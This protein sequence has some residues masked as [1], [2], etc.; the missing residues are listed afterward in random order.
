VVTA[1][2]AVGN[3]RETPMKLTDTQLV[4][5]SAAS[6]R[7]D[8]AIDRG[9]DLKGAASHKVIARLLKEGLVEETPARG[10]VPIWRR[11]D[12]TGPIALRM[13]DRGLAAIGVQ[14]AI[15]SQSA[16]EAS[17]AHDGEGPRAKTNRGRTEQRR[18]SGARHEPSRSPDGRSSKQARVIA[19]LQ[20]QQGA[21]I[22]AIMK[23]TGWQQH[24]VRGFFAGVV[25]KNLGLTLVSEKTGDQ[26]VY[27]I[28][29]GRTTAKGKRKA[30]R[31][32]R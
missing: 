23:A 1:R 10:S 31:K 18:R 13:T 3:R 30:A 26:R 17:Q 19:L 25:R 27:R 9:P 11:D 20:R 32:A 28:T 16:G 24:S 21:T 29:A 2:D 22:A 7:E 8:R 6:Q 14:D 5:L 4:L 15:A 12:E